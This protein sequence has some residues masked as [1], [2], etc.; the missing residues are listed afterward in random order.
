MMADCHKEACATP[1]SPACATHQQ[2][3]VVGN[4]VRGLRGEGILA[5][6]QVPHLRDGQGGEGGVMPRACKHARP[7]SLTVGVGTK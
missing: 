2:P 3:R 6:E 4:A 7:Q 5:M 1:N